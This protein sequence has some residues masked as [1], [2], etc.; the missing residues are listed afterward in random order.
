MFKIKFEEVINV[1]TKY[2]FLLGLIFIIGILFLSSCANQTK[3][4]TLPNTELAYVQEIV[5][6]QD[7]SCSSSAGCLEGE[8]CVEGECVSTGGI[9]GGGLSD[10]SL[11][12]ISN[13]VQNCM[14]DVASKTKSARMRDA[15]KD[16][17]IEGC[18]K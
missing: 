13:C 9:V 2:S 3:S 4:Y 1:K 18:K 16:I 5:E 10:S 15:S 6:N 11:G 7:K 17:C 8:T 14:S 12:E